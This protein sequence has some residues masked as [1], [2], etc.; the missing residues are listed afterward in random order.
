MITKEQ[1][2]KLMP[3]PFEPVFSYTRFK[4]GRIVPSFHPAYSPPRLKKTWDGTKYVPK[5]DRGYWPIPKKNI[6][7]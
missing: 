1:L 2:Q 5:M 4:D 3:K 7:K 6:G